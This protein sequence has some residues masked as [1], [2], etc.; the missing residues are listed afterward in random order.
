MEARDPVLNH[1]GL[2]PETAL[3]SAW[4]DGDYQKGWEDRCI[5]TCRLTVAAAQI[6]CRPGDIS[7]NLTA[8]IEMVRQATALGA[9]ILVF[10]ELS[11]TDY[12]AAP[13]CAALGTTRAAPE[14]ALIGEAA[15]AMQVS[16]GF[17]ERD[18]QGR[19]FNAQALIAGDRIAVHRKLNLPGYGRLREDAVY[20]T[21]EALD[22]IDMRDGWRLATLICADSWNPALPWLAALAGANLLI[23]PVA[24][25]RGAVDGGFDNPRGWE[26]NL[27]H[28]A[29][30]YGLPTI[31][32]NHCGRR[33][34]FDF[35]GGSRI[36]D[37]TGRE[38][39]RAGEEPELISAV[40]DLNDGIT[41]RKNLPTAR[42][43]DP[44]LIHRLLGEYLEASKE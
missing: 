39:A 7:A 10:P 9:D 1:S 20:A 31:F 19:F 42:D 35:W 30:T 13:D 40:I 11:L 43:S 32:A 18:A 4:D 24:S 14:F 5:V 8:H 44:T 22:I 26:I 41:A 34:G 2:G 38:L 27:A 28:T 3:R 21:G 16:V 37:A 15:G 6:A 23:L 25:S 12:L 29:M 36:L 17:I 33:G